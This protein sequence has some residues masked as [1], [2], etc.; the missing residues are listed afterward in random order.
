MC[1]SYADRQVVEVRS[2]DRDNPARQEENPYSREEQG[3]TPATAL[4]DIKTGVAG[5]VYR[6][7]IQ[8]WYTGGE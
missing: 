6:Y 8:P 2:N 1:T 3:V 4:Y 5:M 7:G